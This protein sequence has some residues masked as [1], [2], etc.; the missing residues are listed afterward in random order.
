MPA[1][2]RRLMAI[3][4]LALADAPQTIRTRDG[5]TAVVISLDAVQTLIEE[6]RKR[7]LSV[8]MPR[9]SKANPPVD[10]VSDADRPART[11]IA[12]RSVLRKLSDL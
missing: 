5:R 11:R 12:L 6:A 8:D 1:A 2:K 3:I 4:N 10:T 9:A 7:K